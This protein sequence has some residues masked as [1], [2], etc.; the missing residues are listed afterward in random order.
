MLWN[1][2]NMFIATD[3][4]LG[5]LQKIAVMDTVLAHLQ[6]TALIDT[7]LVHVRLQK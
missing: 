1:V 2:D 7:V 5:S 6:Q 4:I 3:T